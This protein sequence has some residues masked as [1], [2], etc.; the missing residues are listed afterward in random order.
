MLKPYIAIGTFLV[1]L[2]LIVFQAKVDTFNL[3]FLAS[4]SEYLSGVYPLKDTDEA[5]WLLRLQDEGRT[6]QWDSYPEGRPNHWASPFYSL[7]KLT[8][9][10]Y[11]GAGPFFANTLL[12]ILALCVLL[13]LA[14]YVFGSQLGSLFTLGF[15]LF[16]NIWNLFRNSVDHHGLLFFVFASFLLCVI[17]PTKNLLYLGGIFL[18]LGLWLN[19][20]TFIPITAI[21]W[22]YSLFYNFNPWHKLFFCGAVITLIASL[23]EYQSLVPTRI[24]V[25][26]PLYSVALIGLGLLSLAIQSKNRVLGIIGVI[27]ASSPALWVLVQGTQNVTLLDTVFKRSLQ[28][29][30]DHANTPLESLIIPVGLFAALFFISKRYRD[31]II[32]GLLLVLG[33]YVHR[34]IQF[35]YIAC[36]IVYISN[37]PAI[38]K[39]FLTPILVILLL[40]GI[41]ISQSMTEEGR[42]SDYPRVAQSIHF[43]K[44]AEIVAKNAKQTNTPPTFLTLPI[45]ASFL[46]YYIPNSKSFNSIFWEAF[47]RYLET[48]ELLTN[49]NPELVVAAMRDNGINYLIIRKDG[50]GKVTVG[51]SSL[52]YT[53]YGR[54]GLAMEDTAYNKLLSSPQQWF[55]IVGTEGDTLILK[56]SN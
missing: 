23:I 4:K 11:P 38:S 31:L 53:L 19:P 34:W 54:P 48:A 41:T 18:G 46:A 3:E 16:P 10:V 1:L 27:I 22:I 33:I 39:K 32:P 52:A 36:L 21:F 28:T 20:L 17:K 35:A 56:L 9:F 43:Q 42:F 14:V 7:L 50:G 47:P 29:F 6:S 45:D 5:A 55:D 15:F 30:P 25:I 44:V 51:I 2:C 8:N 40:G 49:P 12:A 24:E 13:P 37:I 26:S